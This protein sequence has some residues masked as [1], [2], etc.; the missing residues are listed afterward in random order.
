MSQRI[1]KSTLLRM[2]AVAIC[3]L[4]A[5][6]LAEQGPQRPRTAEG[7]STAAI[8]KPRAQ[9][10]RPITAEEW[11][12]TA[13][14][15]KQNAPERFGLYLSMREG[16]AKEQL[17]QVLV[18]RWRRLEEIQTQMPK[19]YDVKVKEVRLDDQIFQIGR[20]MKKASGSVK[21]QLRS[22]LKT[23]VAE[24]FDNGLEERQLRIADLEARLKKQQQLLE[25][26]NKNRDRLIA[27]SYRQISN[28]LDNNPANRVQEAAPPTRNADEDDQPPPADEN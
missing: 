28:R 21:E 15:M 9:A 5:A 1:S 24:L 6:A 11:A 3:A 27:K 14:F 2:A 16:P 12:K 17:R 20:E 13:E 4:P 22:D 8:V 10:A 18:N 23:K 7:Q 25:A 26:D 19:L